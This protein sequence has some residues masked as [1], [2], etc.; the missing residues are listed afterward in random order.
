MVHLNFTYLST[1]NCLRVNLRLR[2]TLFFV[3]SFNRSGR[4]LLIPIL[5]RTLGPNQRIGD[6][7][8]PG[9]NGGHLLLR[10]GVHHHRR[11]LEPARQPPPG[12]KRRPPRTR[13]RLLPPVRRSLPVPRRHNNRRLPGHLP[14]ILPRRNEAGNDALGRHRRRRPL[15]LTGGR[16]IPLGRDNGLVPGGRMRPLGSGRRGE[17]LRRQV[18]ARRERL[19]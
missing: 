8:D 6:L 9:D 5:P 10:G 3:F 18:V 14:I 16:G 11:D 13:R 4:R 1:Q 19:T 7:R 12:R 17:S 2:T 15:P